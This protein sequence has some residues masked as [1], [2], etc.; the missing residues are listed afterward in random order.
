MTIFVGGGKAEIG[1]IT[2]GYPALETVAAYQML[3][4]ITGAPDY[5][6][7]LS[8][9]G[10]LWLNPFAGFTVEYQRGDTP[11]AQKAIKLLTI[12]LELKF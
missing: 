2:K 4:G 8:L 10:K 5:S 1:L 3:A 6:D 9:S 7:L 12:G 11:V